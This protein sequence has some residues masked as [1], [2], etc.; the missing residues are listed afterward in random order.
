MGWSEPHVAHDVCACG[1]GCNRNRQMGTLSQFCDDAGAP[2]RHAEN[3]SGLVRVADSIDP[4]ASG[5]DVHHHRGWRRWRRMAV[6][7]TNL[8]H[9]REAGEYDEE[10]VCDESRWDAS[11]GFIRPLSVVQRACIISKRCFTRLSL[12]SVRVYRGR[13][14]NLA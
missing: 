2:F 13:R 6:I 10:C 3:A 14:S 5:F 8:H 1:C 12:R 4:G 9:A 7:V 11:S